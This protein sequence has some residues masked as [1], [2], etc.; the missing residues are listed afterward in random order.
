[1]TE[2]RFYHDSYAKFFKIDYRET[3]VSAKK[4][5]RKLVQATHDGDLVQD[6]T[7]G[8]E[9]LSVSGCILKVEQTGL[10]TGGI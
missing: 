7:G 9:K 10:L 2:L 3:S 6:N 5:Q 1:M 8:D 4:N